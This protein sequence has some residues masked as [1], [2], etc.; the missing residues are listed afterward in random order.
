MNF[1]DARAF[2]VYIVSRRD[3]YPNHFYQMTA[4]LRVGDTVE[5]ILTGVVSF[6]RDEMGRTS[7]RFAGLNT[8]IGKTR[9]RVIV[10]EKGE[11]LPQLWLKILNDE[12]RYVRVPCSVTLIDST[13]DQ[14]ALE[15]EFKENGWV[16]KN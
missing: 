8:S 14:P 7:F 15:A 12:H 5:D 11:S 1:V 6:E 4:S 3:E 13:E 16:I 9:C 10:G 2:D